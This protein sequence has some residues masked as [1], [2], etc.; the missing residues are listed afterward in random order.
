[1]MNLVLQ[2]VK[3]LEDRRT[4]PIPHL[5]PNPFLLPHAGTNQIRSKGLRNTCFSLS[6]Q[7]G[8]PSK[9]IQFIFY[10]NTPIWQVK[11]LE[12]YM[13]LFHYSGAPNYYKLR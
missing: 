12:K 4:I 6:P 7:S 11:R 10:R 1:M 5:L 2:S 3:S 13:N 8:T 9:A